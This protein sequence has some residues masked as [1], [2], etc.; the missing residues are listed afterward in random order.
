MVKNTQGGSS[1]K[2]FARKFNTGG[3]KNNKLRVSEDEGEIYGIVIKMLGNNMFHCHCMDGI[4]RL[5]HI[6]GKF[7]GRGKRDNMVECSK[8]VLIGL[9]EWDISEKSSSKKMQQ[10]DLLEIYSDADKLRL[11]E[12]VLENWKLFDNNEA[13]K[14]ENEDDIIFGSDRDFERDTLIREMNSSASQRITLNI[15]E[16]DEEEINFDD[17]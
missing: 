17:I 12:S 16:K 8:W 14:T 4:I 5:G 13:F 2:K 7:T 6:R 10:C 11:R 1:H 9:R 15:E 3:I